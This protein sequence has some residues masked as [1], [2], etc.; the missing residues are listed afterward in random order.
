MVTNILRTFV[1]LIFVVQMHV[2]AQNLNII[3][4]IQL[5]GYSHIGVPHGMLYRIHIRTFRAQF[6]PVC[7][8]EIMRRKIRQAKP[9]THRFHPA[10]VF[11]LVPARGHIPRRTGHNVSRPFM[12]C[13][14]CRSTRADRNDTSAAVRLWITFLRS[15]RHRNNAAIR[16]YIFRQD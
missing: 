14:K 9:F 4:Y 3:M 13:Q 10:A 15:A 1:L 7:M 12:R 16:V 6:R 5:R 2:V 11:T 8:P